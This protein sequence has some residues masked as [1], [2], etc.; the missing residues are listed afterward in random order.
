[1]ALPT[2]H[3]KA[4]LLRDGP[5]K[6]GTWRELPI[7]IVLESCCLLLF[8]A[9]PDLL[10]HAIL[11]IR[12]PITLTPINLKNPGFLIRS[13]PLAMRDSVNSVFCHLFRSGSTF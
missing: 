8:H 6:L 1:M 10:M 9:Q 2:P 12:H 3:E 5:I 7:G 4:W 13:A 11:Y